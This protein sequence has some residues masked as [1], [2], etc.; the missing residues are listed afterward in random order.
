[1]LVGSLETP[2]DIYLIESLPLESCSR[3]HSGFILHIVD[4]ILRQLGTRRENYAS[5]LTDAAHYMS[6]AG[7]S[8]M[9]VT[10]IAYSPHTSAM[11]V[12]EHF[13]NINNVVASMKAATIK[14]RDRK[15]DFREANLPSPPDLVITRWATWLRTALC[16]SHVLLEKPVL[17]T[18]FPGVH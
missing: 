1:M 8:L 3:V 17:D 2:T 9:H 16:C 5:L 4:D 14:N 12:R 13:K 15:I 10:C 7:P 11:R 18:G 6:L